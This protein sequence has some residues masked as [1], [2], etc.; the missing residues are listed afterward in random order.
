MLAIIFELLDQ[1]LW[2][3]HVYTSL[4][5]N[6]VGITEKI[7]VKKSQFKLLLFVK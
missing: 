4:V 6:S 7:Y 2:Y 3:I 1:E 5:V